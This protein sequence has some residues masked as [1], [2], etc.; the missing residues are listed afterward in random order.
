M[1]EGRIGEG[2]EWGPKVS[3]GEPQEFTPPSL[4]LQG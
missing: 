2:K 4:R 3:L 1:G